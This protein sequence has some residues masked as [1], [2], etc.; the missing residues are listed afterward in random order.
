MNGYIM[1][2]TKTLFS[3]A[4][5]AA[6]SMTGCSGLGD[7]GHGSGGG[8]PPPNGNATLSVTLRANPPAPPPGTSIL[9]YSLTVGGVQLTPA[10]G[11]VINVAGSGTFDLTR[12]ESDSAFLGTI[13]VP[14][15][16]YTSMTVSLTSAVV[17]Y[18]VQT[19][20][21]AGCNTSSVNQ[22]TAAAATPVI[23]FPSGGLV[24]TSSQQAGLS[25]DF[26]IGP[27]LTI[28]NQVVT[29][30]NLNAANVLSTITLGS[31]QPS[32][33]AS[34][35]L[36]LLEDVTG[37]VSVTGN[38][39]T[40]KTATHGSLTATANSNTFFSPNCNLTGIG[41]GTNTINCVQNNQVASINAILN[42]DGTMTLQS[43]D[44]IAAVSTTGNDWIEGVVSLNPTSSAQFTIVANDAAL[45]STGSL[46]PSPFPIGTSFNVTFT[47]SNVTFIVDTQGLDVP[48]DLGNFQGASSTSALLP[49]QTVAVHVKTFTPA[50][51]PALATVTTDMVI[52]RFT[53][54]AGTA[55]V[56]GSDTSFALSSTS[57]PLFFGFTTAQQL[58]ELTS[59]TPP[60]TNSTNFDG[61]TTPTN[62]VSGST[63][64]VRALYFG[65]FDAFPLVAAKV[66]QNQ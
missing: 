36:D 54:I 49:G 7:T 63:Y 25:I 55:A 27:T 53:R 38:N 64:S 23:T 42:Q 5:L 48:S 32:S 17:T 35:Q 22:F 26:N 59:G 44:P 56:G 14:A 47:S 30:V 51:A 34:T 21:V 15:G 18:C 39:V 46:L 66:R 19:S 24:L 3:F 57:L 2:H 12:L 41:D 61:V 62:I 65:Q 9:S 8:N 6:V 1:N 11:S 13:S 45:T 58:I 29:G 43:Y 52:L 31:T 20:G 60:S 16:T 10:T 40:I 50:V 33:L 37:N 4:L 28:A